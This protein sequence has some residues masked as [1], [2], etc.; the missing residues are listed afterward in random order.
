[1]KLR[2][3]ILAL[4]FLVG[5]CRESKAQSSLLFEVGTTYFSNEFESSKEHLYDFLAFTFR[6]RV[7]FAERAN[8]AFSIDIPISI[9]SKFGNEVVS[10]FG[11][12]IPLLFTGN[13]GAAASSLHSEKSIGATVGVGW[14]YYY[15]ESKAG[16]DE[17]PSYKES[18]SAFGPQAEAGIRFIIKGISIIKVKNKEVNPAVTIRFSNLFDIKN[19]EHNVGSISATIGFAF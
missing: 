5:A 6:T 1:M 18:I 12:H 15:Q 9:R 2:I 14:G 4:L 7:M 13:I 16:R 10:R 11:F 8:S 17:L 19:K 3:N